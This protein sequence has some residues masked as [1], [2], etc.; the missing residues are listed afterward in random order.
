MQPTPIGIF[1]SSESHLN[2]H[3]SILMQPTPIGIFP[4]KESHL[5]SKAKHFENQVK[6]TTLKKN[7][8]RK[9]NYS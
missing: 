7:N 2:S 3:P 8:Y 5:N 9:L 4:S 1:P 6:E